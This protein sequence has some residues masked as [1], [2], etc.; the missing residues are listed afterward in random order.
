MSVLDT[1]LETLENTVEMLNRLHKSRSTLV[2]NLSITSDDN[3]RKELQI[4]LENVD[5]KILEY[6]DKIAQLNIS[7]RNEELGIVEVLLH[8]FRK[9]NPVGQKEAIK[10]IEEL[11]EI[12]KYR[13]DTE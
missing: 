2:Q 1:R 7:L 13:K 3:T 8:I 4:K 5:Y 12:P 9:L 6:E 11:A 10:R